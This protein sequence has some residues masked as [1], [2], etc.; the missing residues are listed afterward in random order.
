MKLN[1]VKLNAFRGISNVEIP[2]DGR[3]TVIVG[4]NGIGKTSVLDAISLLLT[5]LR[6]IW[7]SGETGRRIRVPSVNA[8]D[9]EYTKKNYK[10]QA[11]V[12]APSDNGDAKDEVFCLTSDDRE[13]ARA[14]QKLISKIPWD[15]NPL[16]VYYRQNRGFHDEETSGDAN[17]PT[18]DEIRMQS[19]APR[20]RAIPDLSKWWDIRDA[21]E[22]RMHRDTRPGYRDPQLQAVRSLI[23]EMN[24]FTGVS[25]EAAL[26]SPGLYLHK[27][28]GA[29]VHVDKLSSGEKVYLILL[30]D[31]ARRL[32][33]VEPGKKLGSISGIVLIDEIELNLHPRW[34]REIISQLA[35][36]FRRCQFIV[37]THSPQ[38]LGEVKGEN[39]RILAKNDQLEIQCHEYT[40]GAYGRD[41]NELLLKVLGVSERDPRIKDEFITLEEHISKGELIEAKALLDALESK[42]EGRPVELEIAK[43]RLRRR[44]EQI[45]K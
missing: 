13:N 27:P 41:S 32:Q 18:P 9:I 26:E 23:T 21:Q 7:T 22:A 38:V 10:I 6:N 40:Q 37:T 28:N 44:L 3:I 24:E 20:L 39:I 1:S 14:C 2:L 5:G 17:L 4:A 15:E 16:F 42:L 45:E 29:V 30:A 11:V 25:F 19:L 34:Q 31:L 36:I 8:S 43:Q 33:M 35:R 12:S